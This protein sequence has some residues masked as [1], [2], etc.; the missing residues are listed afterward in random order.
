MLCFE[1]GELNSCSHSPY[2]TFYICCWPS[3][4]QSFSAPSATVLMT[5][6]YCLRFETPRTWRARS[7]YLYPPGRRWPSYTHRHWVPFSSPPTARRAV[8][9]IFEP[10]PTRTSISLTQTHSLPILRLLPLHEPTESTASH[11]YSSVA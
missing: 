5:V 9:E 7:P 1:C 3:P 11:N 4:A 10:A 8:V 6:F 2:A